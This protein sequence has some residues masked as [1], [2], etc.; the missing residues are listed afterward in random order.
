MYAVSRQ[1]VKN[2]AKN[3]Q[4]ATKLPFKQTNSTIIAS[5]GFLE[6]QHVTESIHF[7]KIRLKYNCKVTLPP[8]KMKMSFIK[9]FL[10]ETGKR[11]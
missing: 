6:T 3:E 2:V 8:I 7:V 4:M 11:K 10:I 1:H 9:R 5:R